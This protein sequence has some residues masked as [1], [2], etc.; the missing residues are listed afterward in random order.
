MCSNMPHLT[1]DSVLFNGIAPPVFAAGFDVLVTIVIIVISLIGWLVNLANEKG[2][3]P[4][5]RAN[6]PPPKPQGQQDDQFQQE[7]D[8]FLQRVGGKPRQQQAQVQPQEEPVEIEVVPEYELRERDRDTQTERRLSSIEDRHV[9][10][11]VGTGFDEKVRHDFDGGLD[12]VLEEESTR[13]RGDRNESQ[14]IPENRGI[15]PR[16]IVEMLRDH[17]GIRRAVIVNEILR[18]PTS[19]R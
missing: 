17:D 18:R 11:H 19:R 9:A 6:V 8:D 10:S 3:Q 15:N 5:R 2:R 16:E 12:P 13:S 14:F 7:I 1:L 4:P